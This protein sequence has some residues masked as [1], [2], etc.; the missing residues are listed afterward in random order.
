MK[1]FL[2]RRLSL[3]FLGQRSTVRGGLLLLAGVLNWGFDDEALDLIAEAIVLVV[4]AWE[5]GR[6]EKP[7]D[8]A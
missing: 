3:A 1:A 2:A 5:A 8:A 4:G 7:A 6:D